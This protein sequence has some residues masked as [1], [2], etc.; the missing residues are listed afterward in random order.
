MRLS[1]ASKI[2]ISSLI[3]FVIAIKTRLLFLVLSLQWTSSDAYST[4]FFGTML[5]VAGII[6]S[7]VSEGEY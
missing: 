3:P 7:F 2:A 4:L 1:L 6:G 5:S